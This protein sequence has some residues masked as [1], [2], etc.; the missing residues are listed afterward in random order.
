MRRFEQPTSQRKIRGSALQA[1]DAMRYRRIALK[2]SVPL[3]TGCVALGL[4]LP[5]TMCRAAHPA[6]G[7]WTIT[8][9]GLGQLGFGGARSG[10]AGS[11]VR[12][13]SED[14]LNQA[15]KAIKQGDFVG[16]ESFIVQAEKLDAKYDV[17]TE[18]FVD[19]PAKIRKLLAEERVKA[20]ATGR[21]PAQPALA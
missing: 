10:N 20:G 12:K 21:L 6:A 2:A 11:H 5:A 16:A 4:T 14:L 9:A 18:R 1:R 19:T 17:L 8:A 15:R 13:K 7:L 3:L